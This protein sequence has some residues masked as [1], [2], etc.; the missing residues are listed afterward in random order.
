[1][2]LE[3]FAQFR[4]AAADPATQRR[5]AADL[6][7]ANM[8]LVTLLVA[9][10]CGW[11]EGARR[12]AVLPVLRG[13]SLLTRDEAIQCGRC[14]FLRALQLFDPAKG[15][16]AYFAALHV[17]VFLQQ[18]IAQHHGNRRPE[19]VDE[20]TLS[21]EGRSSEDIGT[22]QTPACEAS[23][24]LQRVARATWTFKRCERAIF[25]AMVAAEC[26]ERAAAKALGTTLAELRRLWEPLR[27]RLM[28]PTLAEESASVERFL[29]AC[30]V[31]APAG[32]VPRATLRAA[33]AAHIGRDVSPRRF[34][35][36]VGQLGI[37]TTWTRSDGRPVRAYAGLRLTSP[38][39]ES[40]SRILQSWAG[41]RDS[42][43][44]RESPAGPAAPTA[45]PTATI[46]TRRTK[47]SADST[48]P[49]AASTTSRPSMV[50]SVF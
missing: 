37:A 14:G 6:L 32:R 26:Q 20:R 41:A 35:L 2:D 48:A 40:P 22:D 30:T 34:A 13:A 21:R 3:V 12:R 29:E 50:S 31:P 27:R 19:F 25:R 11:P 9:Q 23:A 45:R 1:M 4:H 24:Q 28:A 43:S 16:I 15:K 38:A 10:L 39:P 8:P 42:R 33:Y 17:R 7:A 18:A 5:H 49:S 36:L 47:S 44:R 46:T